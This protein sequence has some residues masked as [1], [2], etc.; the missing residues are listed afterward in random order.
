MPSIVSPEATNTSLQPQKESQTHFSKN[1]IFI[2]FYLQ[3][4]SPT[5]VDDPFSV[6]LSAF[7]M[8]GL[9]DF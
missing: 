3:K 2:L 5:F 8:R 6:T 4:A 1:P 9:G 7:I